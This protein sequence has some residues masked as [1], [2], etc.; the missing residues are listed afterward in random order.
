MTTTTLNPTEILLAE[1]RGRGITLQAHGDK[2]RYR[3]RDQMTPDLIERLKAHK[4]DVLAILAACSGTDQ[5]NPR[6]YAARLIRQARQD[7]DRDRAVAM[8][9][10][11]RERVTICTIDGGLPTVDAQRFAHEEVRALN[12]L[13]LEYA[14]AMGYNTP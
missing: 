7:G 10:C 12:Q 9:D 11:W 2:L 1:L 8:R 14:Q 3:P 13:Y 6:R 5:S 4:D